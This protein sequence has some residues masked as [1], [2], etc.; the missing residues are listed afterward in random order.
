MDLMQ[1]KVSRMEDRKEKASRFQG[2][3][4]RYV[5]GLRSKVAV[6]FDQHHCA[7]GAVADL[8]RKLVADLLH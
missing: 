2:G 5:V 4:V 1:A 7:P 6:T 8:H 3:G